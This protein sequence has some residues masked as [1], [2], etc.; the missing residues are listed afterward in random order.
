V[1]SPETLARSTRPL[2]DVMTHV[3]GGSA[4]EAMAVVALLTTANTTLLVVTSS[5]RMAFGMG[6]GGALPKRVA[7]VNRRGTPWV[8]VLIVVVA[9]AG[10]IGFEDLA[11]IAGA[12]DFAVYV[13]FL[14][15]NAAV[16]VLRVKQ[17]DASRPFRVPFA[18]GR[19]P[20]IP[21]AGSLVTLAMIPQLEIGAIW[22]GLAILA[23]G[24]VA[25]PFLGRRQPS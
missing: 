9:A 4:V 1:L 17:P 18:V 15:V 23:T 11:L 24:V 14:A 13:V 7:A 5:S 21:I 19:I 3:L 2:A 22:I 12:T 8:A 25:F 10:F 20:V 6:S 16:I